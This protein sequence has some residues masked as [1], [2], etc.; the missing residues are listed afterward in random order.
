MKV[1]NKY[2]LFPTE[3]V[4][5][6]TLLYNGNNRSSNVINVLYNCYECAA[7]KMEFSGEK[8]EM[9]GIQ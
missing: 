1:C 3:L 5:D 8:S 7:D 2:Y 4:L 9:I 6:S